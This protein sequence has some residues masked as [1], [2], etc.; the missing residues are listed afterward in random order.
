[1]KRKA[2]LLLWP[3]LGIS[4]MAEDRIS[5]L[6]IWSKDGTKVAYA[7][8]EKPRLMFT[9]SHLWVDAK[10]T[11]IA[12]RLDSLSHFT[13][14]S[15]GTTGLTS[16][17]A[18]ETIDFKNGILLFPALS[19]NSTV[20]I[21]AL[22]GTPVFKKTVSTAGEYAFSLSSLGVG[23]YLVKVNGTTYKIMKK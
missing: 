9:E 17:N 18:G 11:K 22:N 15:I 10:K 6:A 7:L 12:Y 20:S 2:L 4:A 14:E 16:L 19:A 3:L 21:Y 13:Y 5:Q 8:E 1:M 23:V